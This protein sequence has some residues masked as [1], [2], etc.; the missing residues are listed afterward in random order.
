MQYDSLEVQDTK[1][2]RFI[3]EDKYRL[4]RHV[5]LLV[6]LFGVLLYSKDIIE[7]HGAVRY[8]KFFF[9]YIPVVAILYTNMYILVPLLFFKG[10][11]LVYLIVLFVL[12]FIT[13]ML[14]T[15][16]TVRFFPGS[17]SDE[18][19]KL[20]RGVIIMASVI[21]VTTMIKLFQRWMRDSQKIIELNSIR[22]QMELNELKN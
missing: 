15:M 13:L 3:T 6:G 22:M 8:L 4:L 11:Y 19:P 5:T 14:M 7:Y 17:M 10:R 20:L 2:I 12:T 1:V 9:I 16:A 18:S 21:L